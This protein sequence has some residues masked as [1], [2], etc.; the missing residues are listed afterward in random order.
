VRAL[1]ELLRELERRAAAVSET[2]RRRGIDYIALTPSPNFR[3]LAGFS[4]ES[5]E[6]LTL[7]L[8]NSEGERILI[9][10]RLAN[11][12]SWAGG[13]SGYIYME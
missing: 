8:M 11:I 13:Y 7:F 5:Y 3:Y 4:E 2:M 9:A 1:E 12:P 10:P 6:R